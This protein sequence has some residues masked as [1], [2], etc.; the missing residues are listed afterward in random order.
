MSNS[1]NLN[2]GIYKIRTLD[3]ERV[4]ADILFEDST[5]VT[6]LCFAGARD[7]V[8]SR[9]ETLFP[10]VEQ[11]TAND[12]ACELDH[13]E[14]FGFRKQVQGWSGPPEVMKRPKELD[15]PPK[16]KKVS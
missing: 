15:T 12:F 13:I 3:S 7:E 16:P 14:L 1:K 2:S 11:V 6:R 8:E 9:M 5:H 4:T 10:N